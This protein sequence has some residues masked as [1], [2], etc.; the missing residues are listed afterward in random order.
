[1]RIT[2]KLFAHLRANNNDNDILYYPFKIRYC[3]IIHD[4]IQLITVYYITLQYRIPYYVMLYI[5]LS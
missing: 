3:T 1:M 4:I 5:I 2:N